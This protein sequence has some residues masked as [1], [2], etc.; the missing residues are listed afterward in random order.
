MKQE[1]T[2]VIVVAAGLSGLAAAISAAENG[3]KVI[4][5]EKASTTGGA[6]NMG[7]GPLGV[8]SRFQRHHMVSITPGEAFRKHMA[9]THWRVDPRLV[10][11]FYHKS[12]ETIDWLEDMGVQFLTVTPVYPTP[13]ILRPYASSEYTWHVVKPAD[14]STELAPRMAGPMMKAMA[15]RAVDLGVDI[16]LN[17]PVKSLIKENGRVVGVIAEDENGEKIEARA[18]GVIIATGGAGDN[19]TMIKDYT[20]Y[21]WGKDLYSFRVPGM[22]GDGLRMAWDAGATK[23]DIIM[24]IMYLVPE[25]MV[26][27]T[28]FIIDGAFRQPCLWVNSKAERFMN[29][30]AIANTTFAGNAIAAQPGKITYSI[31]DSSL[32]KRYKK[33]GSD[34][35]SHVHPL[36]MFDHFE[37]AVDTALAAGYKHVFKADSIEELAEKMGIDAGTLAATVDEY[38]D[39]CDG[40]FDDIFEKDHR[41]LQPIAK[42]PFYACRYFPSAYGTLGGIKINYKAEVLDDD[43]DPIPGLYAAGLDACTIYGDSY[44]FILPGNTMGF[45]LNSGRIAGENAASL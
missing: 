36:D 11:D 41:Y 15:D 32:L 21:E 39:M 24:E 7:M 5:F 37:E 43:S 44:P 23:T 3:A 13:E 31:F 25:N 38:N 26:T 42:A 1:Q 28:N 8:G 27:P 29:E 6:A 12:G 40:G 14:G 19:P 17:T 20:G 30:D 33:K 45:A 2:D 22:D 34:I 4:A 16:R 35:Q 18:K 10:R 9:F